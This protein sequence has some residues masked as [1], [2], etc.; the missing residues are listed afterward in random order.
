[1]YIGSYEINVIVATLAR[2]RKKGT[3]IHD[4]ITTAWG[5]VIS[6]R[7]VQQLTKEYQ[8]EQRADFKRKDGSGRQKS[9]KRLEIVPLIREALDA[10][11]G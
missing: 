9:E 5:N 3:E 1:M 2:N 7:R 10:N 8:E 4:I 6:L 11:K